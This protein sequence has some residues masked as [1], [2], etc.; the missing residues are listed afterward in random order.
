MYK[1]LSFIR[2]LEDRA[3]LRPD[4]AESLL[5]KAAYMRLLIDANISDKTASEAEKM[6]FNQG[7]HP[8]VKTMEI[9]QLIV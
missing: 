8:L 7:I 9:A 1:M 4:D 3:D 5:E 2:L 6:L